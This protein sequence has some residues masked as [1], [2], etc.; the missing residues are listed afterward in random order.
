MFTVILYDNAVEIDRLRN[1]PNRADALWFGQYHVSLCADADG[2]LEIE[3]D[4]DEARADRGAHF[5]IVQE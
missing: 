4:D 2:E 5:S 1:L 3:L